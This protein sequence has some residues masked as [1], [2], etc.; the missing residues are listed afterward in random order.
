MTRCLV[1]VVRNA[2]RD[3]SPSHRSDFDHVV[4]C[5][6]SHIE[7]YFY[8]QY[9]CHDNEMLDLMDNA[10]RRFHTSK[11]VSQQFRAGQ[12]LA[13]EAEEIH[14]ELCAERDTELNSEV[15]KKKTAALRQRIHDGWKRIIDAE[16]AKYIEDGSDFNFRMI[17]RMQHFQDHIQRYGSR[18]QW[19]TEIEECFHRK[20]I[21]DGFN[22][23]NKTSNY[24]TQM[25]NYYLRSDAFAVRKANCDT[26]NRK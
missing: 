17:H 2:M 6:R 3:A 22:A 25:I 19:S 14:M 9:D 26:L 23:S 15:N 21:K 13:A 18:N 1:G 20:Q 7:L 5:S 8:C 11:A 4:E 24:C 16:M 10:L 12:Q